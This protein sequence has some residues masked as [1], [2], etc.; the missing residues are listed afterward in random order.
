MRSLKDSRERYKAELGYR[1]MHYPA[2]IR[3]RP[4]AR[5]LARLFMP[6]QYR[7]LMGRCAPSEEKC[8]RRG[9]QS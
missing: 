2:F 8:E 5:W 6:V 3:L 4:P 7:R 1:H 9:A